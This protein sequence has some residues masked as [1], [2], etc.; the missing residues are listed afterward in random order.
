MPYSANEA[1]YRRVMVSAGLALLVFLLLLNLTG[2]AQSGA[3]VLLGLLSLSP[4]A[5]DIC[6]QLF[7]AVCY[8]LSFMLPVAV[9]RWSIRRAG[10]R[11]LPMKTE[12][13]LTPLLFPIVLGGIVLIWAQSYLNSALVS[14]F[15]YAS[16]SAEVIWQSS[17][18]PEGYRIVLEFIVMCLVPAICEEFLFRGA[19]LT[20]CLPFGRVNAILISALLFSLMHQNAG[21]ILYAFAAGIFLGVVYERTGSIWACFFLHL[22][23]N[24]ASTMQS[25]LGSAAGNGLSGVTAM[26]LEAAL[27]VGGVLCL[28][29]LVLR[30]APGRPDFREGVFGR[31]VPASDAWAACPI[32]AR[33][34]VRLFLNFPMTLFL[35][36]C[37]LQIATLLLLSLSYG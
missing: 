22:M 18:A 21:Q 1:Y 6:Y 5:A 32:P 10:Y 2:L 33:R 7:Y 34:T 26:A 14:I 31:S 20:N 13:R 35:S 11:Y 27:C 17:G 4:V 15:D 8:L 28:A 3:G 37:V 19:I 12:L 29:Y 25:V 30:L 24:F 23:N 36:L 16:F 9:L